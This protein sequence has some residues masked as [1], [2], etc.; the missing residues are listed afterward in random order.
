[1]IDIKY[2][3]R[4]DVRSGQDPDIYSK[5]L[6][7]VH[8]LLWSKSLPGGGRLDLQNLPGKYLVHSSKDGFFEL[9]S[10]S[11]LHS[12]ISTKRMEHI[13]SQLSN[14]FKEDILRKFYTVGGFILF[15]SNKIDKKLT[16]NGSRGF[17]SRIVDRFDLTLECIRRFYNQETSPLYDTLNRYSDFFKLFQDFK[18]YVDF[19]LL[20]DLVIE[21]YSKVKFF[22]PFDENFPT[23]P[24]PQDKDDYLIFLRNNETFLDG[25]N[26]RIRQWLDDFY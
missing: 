26:Q 12:Y 5:K 22:I 7:K 25:R 21:N 11:I 1:M 24:L 8:K 19:F 15:P 6:N 20:Q 10:D 2:D 23:Q 16:I 13:T 9:S 17:N 14:D 4:K 18:G 3:F